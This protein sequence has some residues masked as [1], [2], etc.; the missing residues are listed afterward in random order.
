VASILDTIPPPGA[1]P[2]TQIHDALAAGT[3]V[4]SGQQRVWFTPYI[5]IIL[6]LDKFVFFINANLLTPAQLSQHGLASAAPVAVDCSMHYA[7][8]GSQV[9]DETIVVRRVEFTS[10]TEIP[11]FAAMAPTVLYVATWDVASPGGSFR[12]T[13]SRRNSF[14]FEAKLYHFLGDAIYPAFE[15]QL[16]D[17]VSQFDTSSVVVS[18]SLPIWLSLPLAVPWPSP[19]PAPSFQLYPSFL[20]PDNLVPP[21]GVVRIRPEDTRA[22]ASAPWIGPSGTRSQ[23]C[24]DRVRVTLYG[25]RNDAASDF[26]DYVMQYLEVAG[27][28]GLMNVPVLR[29]DQRTQVEL[30]ALAQRKTIDYEV[31]Y[32]QHR[33][34]DVVRQV[35]STVISC[36][37]VSAG[38]PIIPISPPIVPLAAA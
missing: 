9:E 31:D 32:Y 22:L 21:Y 10:P 8:T 19:L 36:F 2:N 3:A 25:L 4:L 35:I 24:A 30:T 38:P 37:S 7:S 5:R 33:V 11:A 29:D 13:F 6:P 14:Y 18:N 27:T 26:F 20:V 23:L 12:F 28:M 16:I 15:T 34:R 17:D 1:P